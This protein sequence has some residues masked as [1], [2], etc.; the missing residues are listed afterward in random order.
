MAKIVIN[1]I[2][3]IKR[4]LIE[5]YYDL[6]KPSGDLLQGILEGSAHL[7]YELNG[8]DFNKEGFCWSEPMGE[9]S[10]YSVIVSAA[11]AVANEFQCLIGEDECGSRI[12]TLMTSLVELDSKGQYTSSFVFE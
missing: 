5:H 10:K 1:P 6:S 2:A 4:Y 3:L 7:L 9:K 11:Y 8:I 12:R